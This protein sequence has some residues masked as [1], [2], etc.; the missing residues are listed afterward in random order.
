MTD[1]LR[2]RING[3]EIMASDPI[4]EEIHRLQEENEERLVHLNNT[5]HAKQEINQILSAIVGAKIDDT[6]TVMLPFHTD[7]GKHITLGKHVFINR[8]AMFVDLGGITLDDHVL[9]G[10]RVNLI[11]V[12]HLIDPPNRRGLLTK[13][14]HIKKNAWIGAA[15][16]VLPGVTIGENS[17]V[18]AGAI[19]TKDVPDNVIVVGSPAKIIKKIENV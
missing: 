19:V 4:F 14:I 5:F 3:R 1:T 7:F 10:P 2:K 18:A 16:T 11:T 15:A 13:P 17:V 9:I 6:V 12:N 8:N